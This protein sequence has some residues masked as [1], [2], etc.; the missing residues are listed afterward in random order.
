MSLTNNLITVNNY[1]FDDNVN[2]ISNQN[3]ITYFLKRHS[4]IDDQ[5]IDDF[6][7]FYDNGHNEYDYT[8]NLEKLAYW[9]EVR[10]DNLKTLLES[11]F[12]ENED[13]IIYKN[14]DGKGMGS[15]YNKRKNI[16]LNYTCAKELCMLSRSEKSSVIRKFYIDLEKLIITYKDSIVRD[17]ERCVF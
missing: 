5:F 3:K 1:K 10:K 17:L 14:K 8:I 2:I 7:S 12:A 9:L 15:G 13:Y 11:N 6:Y 4:L 16:M